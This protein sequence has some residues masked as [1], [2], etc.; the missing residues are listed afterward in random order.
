MLACVIP[1]VQIHMTKSEA[2]RQDTNPEEKTN[3]DLP[4][5]THVVYSSKPDAL[6]HALLKGF[7]K[8]QHDPDIKR[9][10]LFGG[11]YENIYLTSRQ[12]PQLGGL[13][14]EACDHASRFLNMDDLQA[15]CWFNFMPSGS[16]TSVH[17]HD[18]Y[19]ELMSAVYYVSVPENSGDLIIHDGDDRHVI[20]PQEGMFVFFAPDV[21]HE[22]SR[23]MS[24]DDRLSI[25][26]NF[27]R[28]R[29]AGD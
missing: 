18:D 29:D 8:H 10:H 17:S 15:D 9:T 7:L 22:V 27:G 24:S 23:N 2:N 16:V 28:R 14:N 3:I 5:N 12:I 4:A 21:V 20:Q 11:R 6:N 25:A 26:I 19:D 13:L 1:G